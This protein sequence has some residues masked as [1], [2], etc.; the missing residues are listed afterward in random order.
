MP[1]SPKLYRVKR[2]VRGDI[3][4]FLV[5][6]DGDDLPEEVCNTKSEA[7]ALCDSLNAPRVDGIVHPVANSRSASQA[8]A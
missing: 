8:A 1:P 7:E 2:R 4:H 3:I 6:R 5:I